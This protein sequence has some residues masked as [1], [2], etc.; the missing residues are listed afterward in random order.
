MSANFFSDPRRAVD[1]RRTVDSDRRT[2]E[3]DCRDM[4]AAI[5]EVKPHP[6]PMDS[7]DRRAEGGARLDRFSK[8]KSIISR[9]HIWG[10]AALVDI[11]IVLGAAELSEGYVSSLFTDKPLGQ[12]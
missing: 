1:N 11:A 4:P 8:K 5:N 10:P 9:R 7:G 6:S 2:D 3:N 12:S